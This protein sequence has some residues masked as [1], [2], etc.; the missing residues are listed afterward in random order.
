MSHIP[1]NIISLPGL[2]FR[3]QWGD[4]CSHNIF[5]LEVNALIQVKATL[6]AAQRDH[7]H[8]S[9]HTHPHTPGLP[10]DTARLLCYLKLP[11]PSQVLHPPADPPA[12]AYT[13]WWPAGPSTWRL[14]PAPRWQE[15]EIERAD[16]FQSLRL[17]TPD[18]RW[19]SSGLQDTASTQVPK[20][21]TWNSSHLPMFSYCHDQVKTPE[22]FLNWEVSID[23]GERKYS[24]E[25]NTS[26]WGHKQLK[27]YKS[28][29]SLPELSMKSL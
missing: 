12:A 22:K 5:F 7:F 9:E 29:S 19:Y 28:N 11:L 27:A 20:E 10:P 1:G 21:H 25:I 16:E 6:Q 4:M 17:H 26:H 2:A 8:A 14:Q 13:Q 3:W 23:S 18:W 15:G 24:L